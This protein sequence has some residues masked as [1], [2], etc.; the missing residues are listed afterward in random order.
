MYS[1]IAEFVGRV[2][3]AKVAINWIGTDALFI[4]EPVAWLSST[5][6]LI[7]PYFHYKKKLL[8]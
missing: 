1:G 8:N 6:L 5:L 3:M 7:I 4:S 2:L